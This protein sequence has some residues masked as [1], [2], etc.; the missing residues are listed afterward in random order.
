MVFQLISTTKASLELWRIRQNLQFSEI[1][2]RSKRA[3]P[4]LNY[5]TN[6]SGAP[7]TNRI[8]TDSQSYSYTY[9]AAGNMTVGAGQSYSYDGANRLKTASGGTSS[10]GYD[11]DGK[12]VKKTEGGTT[13]Y[14]VYSSKL[15]QS[16]MEVTANSVQRAYVYGGGKA[17]AMQSPD[18]Q[19]YWLHKSHLG[20]SRAMT[21][22]S[23]NLTYK[24]QFD[25]YGQTLTE[26][27]GSGNTN[28][29]S[30]KFTG[31]ERD[32]A[33]G[34][35]Y[36]NARM[37]NS[38]RGRFTVPDMKGL[39]SASVRKPQSLNRYAYTGNDPVNFVDP[40]GLD[41][42]PWVVGDF[43][44]TI[45]G[46]DG[47]SGIDGGGGD[48]VPLDSPTLGLP[49][50]SGSGIEPD[51]KYNTLTRDEKKL[52]IAFPEACILVNLAKN[53]ALQERQ[54]RYGSVGANDDWCDNAF[55]HAY[56]N[57]RMVQLMSMLP[58]ESTFGATG[59][60]MA[61]FFADAHEA[62][63]NN[64]EEERQMDFWNNNVGR[65]IA[66]E[67]PNVTAQRLA[68]LIQHEV[69]EGRVLVMDAER[70]APRHPRPGECDP[71]D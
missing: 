69:N 59:I 36:A 7:S 60:E 35:D 44:V 10:Y 65:I 33:T 32:S 2:R 9:D 12:R 43:S 25:P 48:M 14:Y 30:K 22:W 54:R 3:T 15:G 17:V 71:N 41:E 70:Q 4:T 5:Q 49:D 64:P 27:S 31:Y 8:D 29:N 20:N 1:Y 21:D 47:F 18:G 45:N 57:A 28:L 52:C 55:L 58:S 6:A 39:K 38:T 40:S 66:K 51:D 37:Y 34:L 13:T 63:P 42:V 16:V 26:W 11:G 50:K 23:G 61:K 62:R 53:D 24:G 56:W 68:D 46:K 19:F 67:N